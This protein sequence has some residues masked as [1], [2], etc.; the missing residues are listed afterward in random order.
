[1]EELIEKT[2]STSDSDSINFIKKHQNIFKINYLSNE[3]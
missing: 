2:L 3:P 1:M